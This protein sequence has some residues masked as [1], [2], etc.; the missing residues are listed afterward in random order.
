MKRLLLTAALVLAGC[1]DA[2]KPAT[3]GLAATGLA[4]TAPACRVTRVVDGDTLHMDCGAGLMKVRL[5]GY[6]TPEVY[7]PKCAAEAEAG[8]RASDLL[9]ALVASGPVTAISVQ[10]T[11]RYGRAL[12][13]VAIAGRDVTG[14]MLASDLALPYTGHQHP[15]WCALL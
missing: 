7:S 13:T 4:A 6:D 3:T 12:A 15:D 9:A 8:R 1:S 5:L 10:G 11:D 14:A 2:P